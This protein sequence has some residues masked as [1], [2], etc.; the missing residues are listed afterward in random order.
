MSCCCTCYQ[1][2]CTRKHGTLSALLQTFC[3]P[4]LI[5]SQ[6]QLHRGSDGAISL[7]L[8]LATRHTRHTAVQTLERQHHDLRTR[9]ESDAPSKL[10]SRCP[11]R[12]V[13]G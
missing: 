13:R 12:A 2:L 4:D 5:S 11:R 6:F 10:H 7:F 3:G 1:P 8:L 9:L